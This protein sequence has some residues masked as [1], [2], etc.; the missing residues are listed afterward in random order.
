SHARSACGPAIVA[1]KKYCVMVEG[2]AGALAEKPA[3]AAERRTLLCWVL[4]GG[5]GAACVEKFCVA[6]GTACVWKPGGAGGAACAL[7]PGGAGGAACALK[8]G[9][10]GGAPGMGGSGRLPTFA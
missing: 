4:C 1:G 7:K 10:V 8:P 6:A 5:G 3:G 2:S 9:G